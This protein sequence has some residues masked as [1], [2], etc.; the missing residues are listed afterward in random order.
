MADVDNGNGWPKSTHTLDRPSDDATAPLSPPGVVP[1]AMI[2]VAA[3]VIEHS[4]YCYCKFLDNLR[5]KRLHL[6]GLFAE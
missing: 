3:I 6:L 1:A 4:L 5:L 2:V